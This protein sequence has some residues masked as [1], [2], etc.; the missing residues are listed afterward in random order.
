M[1]FAQAL[2]L[3]HHENLAHEDLTRACPGPIGLLVN[4]R[5]STGPR[6]RTTIEALAQRLGAIDTSMTRRDDPGGSH[7]LSRWYRS[8][9]RTVA[10][11]GGDGTLLNVLTAIAQAGLTQLVDVALLDGG[12][13]GLVA[14][15]LG[16]RDSWRRVLGIDH[17]SR[18]ISYAPVRLPTFSIDGRLGFVAG[19]GVVA[20]VSRDFQHGRR[21]RDSVLRYA[22]ARLSSAAL[23]RHS[24]SSLLQGYS[25]KF[26]V[27]GRD[28]PGK[29]WLGAMLTSLPQLSRQWPRSN[30]AGPLC[31]VA[32]RD[33]SGPTVR[34]ALRDL[35]AGRWDGEVQSGEHVTFTSDEPYDL[36]ADGD[37]VR[38]FDSVTIRPGPVFH[39]WVPQA[40]QHEWHRR[41]APT[42]PLAP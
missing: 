22:A 12:S 24:G 11:V 35:F 13:L 41:G 10:V 19:L 7:A 3:D 1:S 28:V 2:S 21:T 27:D 29:H 39:G 8:G 26:E 23:G 9:I 18:S 38:V 33:N 36:L 4:P 30:G 5:T 6:N 15:L 14:R 34:P 37:I 42:H 32:M 16:A 20:A 17:L 25:G 31:T 40:D